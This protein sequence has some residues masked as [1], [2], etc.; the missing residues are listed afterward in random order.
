MYSDRYWEVFNEIDRD[1]DDVAVRTF[2][3]GL[4]AEHDLRNSL[5][6]KPVRSVCRLMD[7]INEYKRVEED[8]QQRKGKAKVIPQDRRDFRSD[9]YNNNK[10]R[11]DFVGQSRS[12]TPQVV[13]TVF[14]EP[15]H[16][17][18]EKIKNESYFKWSNKMGEGPMTC[19]QSLHS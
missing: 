2:K 1:F 18:F 9:R 17:V 8:Q 11:R 14:R 4:P 19:N 5:T 16:Q 15:V 6:K 3:V 12:T 13:N 7:R 10:S